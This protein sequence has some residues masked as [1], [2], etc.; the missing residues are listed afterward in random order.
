[1]LLVLPTPTLTGGIG[2]SYFLA[3]LASLS[4]M[5]LTVVEDRWSEFVAKI[6]TG[7]TSMDINSLIQSVLRDSYL[8]Q[9][10]DLQFYA[11]KVT[12]YNDLKEGIRD[13]IAESRDY[14][15][16]FDDKMTGTDTKSFSPIR[17]IPVGKVEPE[18]TMT[19]Q[20]LEQYLILESETNTIVDEYNTM[21]MS[22]QDIEKEMT[23]LASKISENNKAQA[24]LRDIAAYLREL[25]ADPNTKWPVTVTYSTSI[26]E[27]SKTRE[28]LYETVNND[29]LISEIV[30]NAKEAILLADKLAEEITKQEELS[31]M[32]MMD[33]QESMQEQAQMMQAF[34]NILKMWHDE[35]KSIINNMK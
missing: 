14:R 32:M 11:D 1:M 3:A 19:S 9:N 12:Y 15:S 5:N 22:L 16:Q 13:S 2:D 34:S 18:P 8:E 35:A 27:L 33:L 20:N 6:H 17:E 23:E 25:A 21:Y 10:K 29:N 24:E 7:D 4:G 26:I 28:G 30:N 31:Q